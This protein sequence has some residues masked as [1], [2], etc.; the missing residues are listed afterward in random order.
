MAPEL[1]AALAEDPDAK[2]LFDGLKPAQREEYAQYVRE[3]KKPETRTRRGAK[4]VE[5]VRRRDQLKAELKA[6][7]KAPIITAIDET[8]NVVI[9]VSLEEDG[10]RKRGRTWTRETAG[11]R[12]TVYALGHWSNRTTNGVFHLFMGFS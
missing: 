7:G 2:A 9:G 1:V 10:F 11:S 3:A 5:L 8:L 4:V 6:R 12:R